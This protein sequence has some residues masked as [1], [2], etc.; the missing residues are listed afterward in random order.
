MNSFLFRRFIQQQSHLLYYTAHHE[1]MRLC[2]VYLR[3]CCYA[4]RLC[5]TKA[6]TENI[7]S[8]QIFVSYSNCFLMSN[9]FVFGCFILCFVSFGYCLCVTSLCVCVCVCF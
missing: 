3:Y 5:L 6:G 1:H 2:Y 9:I 4:N 7:T 8:A